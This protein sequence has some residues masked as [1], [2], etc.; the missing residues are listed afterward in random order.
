MR[1]TKQSGKIPRGCREN[2]LP[3][4]LK[5]ALFINL[6]GDNQPTRQG[7]ALRAVSFSDLPA[8]RQV[9]R[10]TVYMNIRRKMP[11]SKARMSDNAFSCLCDQHFM[12][13]AG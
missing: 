5:P 4:G 6:S 11:R 13:N 3:E 2:V 10:Q 9:V 8:G 12:N 7:K 1:R